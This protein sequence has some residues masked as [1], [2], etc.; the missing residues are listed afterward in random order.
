[1]NPFY[2]NFHISFTLLRALFALL[3]A[4]TALV[5][6]IRVAWANPAAGAGYIAEV[7]GSAWRVDPSTR[8]WASVLRNQLIGQGDHLRTDPN[9]RLI[10]RMGTTTLWLDTQTELQVMQINGAT[11]TLRLLAGDVAL[12]MRSAQAVREI[13]VQTREGVI[14]HPM[15]GLV[16]IAQGNRVTRVGV[17]QGRAQFDSDPGAPLQ[18]AWLRE[19]EQAEFEWADSARMERQPL[20]FDNFSAWFINRDQFESGLT[21][22]GEVYYAPPE[23]IRAETVYPY[24]NR[25]SAVVEYGRVWIPTPPARVWE[26]HSREVEPNRHPQPH[27][28]PQI[29]PEV[30]KQPQPHM[31]QQ[32]EPGHYQPRPNYDP[33]APGFNRDRDRD[34]G[35]NSPEQNQRPLV[36]LANNMPVATA[37][38]VLPAMPAEPIPR[39]VLPTAQVAP[40]APAAPRQTNPVVDEKRDNLRHNKRDNLDRELRRKEVDPLR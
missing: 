30:H 35:R 31:Q 37:M 32:T 18:R 29:Q 22:R 17:L 39:V 3:V 19:G 25:G 10:V 8:A 11:L 5:A 2:R 28:R 12:R 7:V 34:R 15:D 23:T 33:Q 20:G 27:F 21:Q 1:M 24:D 16:R 6:S 14:S 9:S 40:A 38:P 4:C 26:P 36:P 13:R